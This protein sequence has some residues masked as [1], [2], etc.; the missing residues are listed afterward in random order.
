MKSLKN[1]FKNRSEKLQHDFQSVYYF[2][3]FIGQ[4]PFTI[5]NKSNKSIKVSR[6][7]LFDKLWFLISICIHLVAIYYIIK[8]TKL[9]YH[10]SDGYNFSSLLFNICNFPF[11]LF[12]PVCILLDI[13]NRNRL[14][15]I[16]NKFIIFDSEVGSK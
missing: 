12:G 1:I 10:S 11:I 5:I 13:F 3:R 9:N 14:V 2:S 7:H 16:L 15:N 6:V 4:W 8:Y